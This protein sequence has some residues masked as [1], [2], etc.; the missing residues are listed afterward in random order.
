MLEVIQADFARL[1]TETTATEN[2]AIKEFTD[3]MKTSEASKVVQHKRAHDSTDR[4]LKTSL[5]T[6]FDTLISLFPK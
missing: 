1:E 3:F 2:E 5:N 6:F 4:P